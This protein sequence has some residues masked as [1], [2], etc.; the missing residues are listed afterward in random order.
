M[1][2][3][4]SAVGDFGVSAIHC[5]LSREQIAAWLLTDLLRI[6]ETGYIQNTKNTDLWKPLVFVVPGA[7]AQACSSH[8]CP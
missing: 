4:D 1:Y 8:L 3:H 2:M 6:Q 5:T 7:G